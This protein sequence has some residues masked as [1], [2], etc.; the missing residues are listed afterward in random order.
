LF[1]ELLSDIPWAG[2]RYLDPS[3][4]EDSAGNEHVSNVDSGVDRVEKGLGEV[5]RRR[6]VVSETGSS[7]ELSRTFARLPDTDKADEEVLGK[8]TIEHLADEEDVGREGGLQHDWHVGGVEEADREGTAHAALSRR[9]DGDL[10]TKALEVDNSGKD[11]AGGQEVR[12]VW[13]ALTVEGL[14]EGELLVG[15]GEE[16]VEEGD[17][18]AL[19]FRTTTGVDGGR[20]EGLPHNRLTDVGSDEE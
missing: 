1:L 6:H 18:C 19:E 8:A 9:L 3:L 15:P 17:D 5:E 12:N 14:A 4:G 7:K 20:R 16:E 13:Q 10:H 11:N 2:A